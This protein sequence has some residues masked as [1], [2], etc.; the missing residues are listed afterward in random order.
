MSELQLKKVIVALDNMD[1][2]QIH[3]W[4]NKAT[5]DVSFVKIGLEAYCR[6]GRSLIESLMKTYELKIFLDLKL[7]DIPNTVSKTISA[8]KG[9]P[10]DFLTVHLTGGEQMLVA[11]L[12][13]QKKALPHTQLLGVSYLTS[14]DGHDF[15][16]IWGIDEATIPKQFERLFNLAHR[17]KIHGLVCSAQEA[18]T[19]RHFEVENSLS[20][21]QLVCPGIRFEDEIKK[22]TNL[23]DQKRV[24]SPQE[25]FSLDVDYLVMGRSLTQTKNLRQRLDELHHVE[26]NI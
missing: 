6:Y 14:L 3:D 13:A 20:P 16:Q 7:H 23:G 12:D 25:A 11:A 2:T 9:L 10:I 5:P 1:E 26:K 4:M 21:L 19:L 18:K 24:L 17:S 15:E 22:N 8:L